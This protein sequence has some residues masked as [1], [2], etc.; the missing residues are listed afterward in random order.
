MKTCLISF[1]SAWSDWRS[2]DTN[3]HVEG[4]W[5]AK[6]QTKLHISLSP[7]I[8]DRPKSGCLFCPQKQPQGGRCTLWRHYDAQGRERSA[9][10]SVP[11]FRWKFQPKWVE[12]MVHRKAK[13]S[14]LLPYA[15]FSTL[16]FSLVP[17]WDK[18]M[19]PILRPSFYEIFRKRCCVDQ[20]SRHI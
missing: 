3:C 7:P 8:T 20:Q 12:N 4:F 2:L 1:N 11:C 18:E 10:S 13:V 5:E 15:L 9:H 19:R 16:T 6:V 14:T 17:F